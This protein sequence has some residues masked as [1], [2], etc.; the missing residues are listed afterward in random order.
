M[1]QFFSLNSIYWELDADG[2]RQQRLWINTKVRWQDVTR[3]VSLWSSS[4]YDLEIEY[5]RHRFGPKTGRIRANP[6]DREQFLTS[7][8][9]FAPQTEYV[10][11][12]SAKILNL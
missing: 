12:S 4:F 7:L 1:L 6:A 9:R 5:R 2:I 3:V 10:D 11:E 8:R